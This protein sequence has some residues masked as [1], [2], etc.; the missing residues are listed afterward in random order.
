M[1][2]V[3]DSS[4]PDALNI[5]YDADIPTPTDTPTGILPTIQTIDADGSSRY[6]DIQGRM[7][8]GKPDKGLYIENG[9]KVLVK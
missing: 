4:V 6:F 7:L 1:T 8:N 5:L 2:N 9:K 3:S